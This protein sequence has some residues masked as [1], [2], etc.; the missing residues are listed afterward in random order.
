MATR[1]AR[2][3][4]GRSLVPARDC[5]RCR[6]RRPG[7]GRWRRQA[8]I[9]GTGG[10]S[11]ANR[12]SISGQ[13]CSS[14]TY[15]SPHTGDT[16][17]LGIEQNRL[18]IL[19]LP[20]ITPLPDRQ[21][22]TSWA[23]D[24][25]ADEIKRQ[26]PALISAVGGTLPVTVETFIQKDSVLYF[27]R[28]KQI[29][30]SRIPVGA[31][32]EAGVIGLVQNT[33]L[34]R[35]GNGILKVQLSELLPGMPA[36]LGENAIAVLK[37]SGQRIWIRSTSGGR[38]VLCGIS[39]ET[40][41]QFAV[42]A[43]GAVSGEVRRR[44]TSGII[45]RSSSSLSLYWLPEPETGWARLTSDELAEAVRKRR[46]ET[47]GVR[48]LYDDRPGP[49]TLNGVLSVRREFD[50]LS[51]GATLD[52]K[53]FSKRLTT[54][55]ANPTRS[56]RWL[57]MASGV[58]VL[59]ECELPE[60][61]DAETNTVVRL[62]VSHRITGRQPLLIGTLL[63][64]KKYTLDLPSWMTH[65]PIGERPE[66]FQKYKEW[67]EE[68][69]VDHVLESPS[70]ELDRKVI[71][72]YRSRD[73]GEYSA[74]RANQEHA[75]A[76]AW[77]HQSLPLSEMDPALG[78]MATLILYRNGHLNLRALEAETGGREH[79][80]RRLD[81]CRKEALRLLRHM[82]RRA[83]HSAHVEVLSTG[84][85]CSAGPSRTDDLARRLDR[86]RSI[87]GTVVDRE[88]IR[89]IR[90]FCRAAELRSSPDL[91]SIGLAL[92][93]AMGDEIE[94]GMLLGDAVV[95][96]ELLALAS[97]LP[98]APGDCLS[99]IPSPLIDRLEKL[100]AYI[101]HTGVVIT[102]LQHLVIRRLSNIDLTKQ[103]ASGQV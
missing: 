47:F 16:V 62:E 64:A 101:Q 90:Q 88:H 84:W 41:R 45:C 76:R 71:H 91:A 36:E 63:G 86:L 27:S 98:D 30:N 43:I 53:L 103:A 58:G 11:S 92:R 20:G 77:V 49:V 57:A 65:L 18:V 6:C 61:Y 44:L 60:T 55:G 9:A 99:D 39:A 33:V 29:R 83:S 79:W 42:E 73:T 40:S 10:Y 13:F 12:Y 37:V 23:A 96:A 14:F 22:E 89:L 15:P 4:G 59:F 56:T 54:S 21:R 68:E 52:A 19:G 35:C 25:L 97:A 7:I 31:V 24:D 34:L 82:G 51:P 38:S 75:I 28:R 48:R 69:L 72:V 66:R 85:L 17:L 26:L 8:S 67:Q 50:R 74:R 1:C 46:E 80:S 100:V 102:L 3:V 95:I 5:I 94:E 93:A 87:L 32:A 70:E 78:I 2:Y 81:D